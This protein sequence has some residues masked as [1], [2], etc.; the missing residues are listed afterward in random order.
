M[1]RHNIYDRIFSSIQLNGDCW[2]WTLFLTEKGY[3]SM[4]VSGQSRRPHRVSYEL[5]IGEI[6][7][8]KQIDHLC[9]NR[10]CIN[11]DHLEAVSQ[12]ENISRGYSPSALN[13]R[14]TEC[15]HG[16]VFD[17]SNTYLWSGKRICKTCVG[18]NTANRKARQKELSY[19]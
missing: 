4:K 15:K 1:N 5:F 19:V 18:I 3:G 7:K 10:R 8:D 6:S 9:R 17:K 2:E 12:K 16:H 13:S 14:K 11:P